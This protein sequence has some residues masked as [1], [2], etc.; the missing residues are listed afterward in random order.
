MADVNFGNTKLKRFNGKKSNGVT[1]CHSVCAFCAFFGYSFIIKK[2]S[3]RRSGVSVKAVEFQ[4]S[5]SSTKFSMTE[6]IFSGLGSSLPV[7]KLFSTQAVANSLNS[8]RRK[9][10]KVSLL[11]ES[12]IAWT[13]FFSSC[14]W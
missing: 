8:P 10:R 5:T 11:C 13:R 2:Y 3:V 6:L 1:F 9:L 4:Y 12:R 14:R 7:T